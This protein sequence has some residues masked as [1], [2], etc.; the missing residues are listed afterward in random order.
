M[1]DSH[2]RS[3]RANSIPLASITVNR[4]SLLKTQADYEVAVREQKFD[5]DPS[6]QVSLWHFDYSSN[7]KA[8]L[9]GK[10]EK[11]GRGSGYYW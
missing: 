2:L 9:D 6:D 3:R 4:H 1:S 10:P 5:A 7:S 8:L 11:M